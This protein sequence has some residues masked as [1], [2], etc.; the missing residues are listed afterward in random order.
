MGPNILLVDVVAKSMSRIPSR[1]FGNSYIRA[2]EK[3]LF[4]EWATQ[5]L[6]QHPLCTSYREPS[7]QLRTMLDTIGLIAGKLEQE[8]DVD[9]SSDDYTSS[10]DDASAVEY[11]E[12]T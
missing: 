10:D 1:I 3:V 12:Q 11:I 2:P 6:D 9:A 5:Y 4:E 8:L 7:S